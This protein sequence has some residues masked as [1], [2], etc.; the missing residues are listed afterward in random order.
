MKFSAFLAVFFWGCLNLG[1]LAILA[2]FGEWLAVLSL[3]GGAVTLVF[4]FAL[5]V[6][7]R[8]RRG[9]APYRLPRNGDSILILVVGILVAGL[10]WCF[11]W[12]LATVAV[13]PLLLALR[14]EITAR[15]RRA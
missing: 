12:R 11:Y 15:R 10:A 2:G 14:R 5:V 8:R 13:L 1:L 3:Y 7:L 9:K 6:L 4:L